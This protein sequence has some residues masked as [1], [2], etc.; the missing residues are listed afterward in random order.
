MAEPQTFA[1]AR[2][3]TESLREHDRLAAWREFYSR[4]ALWID[5]EPSEP[6]DC[7]LVSRAL[8]DLQLFSSKMSAVRITRMSRF[9]ADDTDDLAFMINHAG[10]ITASEPMRGTTLEAGEAVL[11]SGNDISAFRRHSAGASLSLRIPRAILSPIVADID[12][13]VMHKIP[14]NTGALRLLANYASAL[15]EDEALTSPEIRAAAVHHVHDLV[16]LTLGA[17]RQGAEIAR[18]RGLPAAR[19]KLAKSYILA[20]SGRHDLS[21]RA[22]AA[23]LG[24]TPRNVQQLFERDGTTFSAYVL[25]RRL[26]RA[27]RMLTAPRFAH[28]AIGA[29][30]YEVGFGDL[31]YFNRSFKQRFGVTPRDVRNGQRT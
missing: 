12:G 18:L 15:V 27:H 26:T 24:V 4:M 16:A 7:T 23:Q 22:V 21:V 3:S 10:N 11:M 5:A 25:A 13:A 17:T 29:I 31:S 8:P 14:Q 28:L 30:A 2:F 9:A 1:A 20:N 6:F 19:L